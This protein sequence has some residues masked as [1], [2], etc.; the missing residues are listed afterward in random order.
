MNPDTFKEVIS[1]LHYDDVANLSL[2]CKTF[3]QLIKARW[4]KEEKEKAKQNYIL[5]NI[6][7]E[8]S[9][10]KMERPFEHIYPSSIDSGKAIY[11]ISIFVKSPAWKYE[12]ETF[13]TDNYHELERCGYIQ[14]GKFKYRDIMDHTVKTHVSFGYS[15]CIVNID[16]SKLYLPNQNII[17]IIPSSVE[18]YQYLELP[19]PISCYQL[20]KE[21]K[22]VKR[23]VVISEIRRYKTDYGQFYV[24]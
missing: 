11:K 3:Q 14:D 8:I 22:D 23:D 4:T 12:L 7:S 21:I 13:I 1:F 15:F 10:F 16:I 17:L 2:T 24:A 18:Q 20:L 6:V 9:A 5:K 19:G